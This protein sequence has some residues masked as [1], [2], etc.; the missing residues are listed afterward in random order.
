MAL[1]LQF[2][3]QQKQKLATLV[4]EAS[5]ID[6]KLIEKAF[7]GTP[8]IKGAGF[9]ALIL[10]IKYLVKI[11]NNSA[12]VF[13]EDPLGKMEDATK[14]IAYM[15]N[16]LERVIAGKVASCKA[17]LI[18]MG[19]L[20]GGESARL[21]EKRITTF[22]ATELDNSNA[23]GVEKAVKNMGGHLVN[24]P[25]ATWS[26]EVS[27]L[28]GVRIIVAYWQ[29]EE[30]IPSGASIFLGEE[31]KEVDISI[32]ELMIIV[33]IAMNRFVQF[34]RKETGRKPKLYNSLYL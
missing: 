5:T 27:P 20:K 31:V 8:Y 19:Q 28:N 2:D 25:T 10:G 4:K 14:L 30:G 29:G 24:H 1:R 18:K 7:G 13:Y 9:E 3:S 22:I 32:E 12:E 21:Y 23:S 11:S 33:E 34:Y 15:I 16:T 26:F 6:S 17:N